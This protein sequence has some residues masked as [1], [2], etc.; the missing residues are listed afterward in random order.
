MHF[1]CTL[2]TSACVSPFTTALM[3]GVCS[4]ARWRNRN[5]KSDFRYRSGQS[6]CARSRRFILAA[7]SLSGM[8]MMAADSH[9]LTCFGF[10]SG[11]LEQQAKG[12]LAP[13]LMLW[14]RC[15][16]YYSAAFVR[17][18]LQ[19]KIPPPVR[20][21]HFNGPCPGRSKDNGPQLKFCTQHPFTFTVLY[22][23]FGYL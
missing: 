15:F 21:L 10:C 6:L 23:L 2:R 12:S 5:S 14:H 18:K 20:L 17:Y 13:N 8:R 3:R 7:D 19:K 22:S 16:Y 9:G 11:R 1:I 4:Y